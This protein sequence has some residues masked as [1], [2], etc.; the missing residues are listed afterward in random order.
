MC[1]FLTAAQIE[2]YGKFGDPPT[3]SELERFFF[4]DGG[5]RKLIAKRRDDATR[6]GF[7]LQLTTVRF[8][9]TLL[10]NPIDVPAT[11][12]AYV[13]AQLGRADASVARAY[14]KRDQTRLEHRWETRRVDG[15]RDFAESR[16]ALRMHV[17]RR[18]WT[19]G[20]GRN[21]IFDGAVAAPPRGAAAGGEHLDGGKCYRWFLQDH[22][23]L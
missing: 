19:T 3:D 1:A 16:E 6:L 2:L 14:L 21:A 11:I 18:A 7:A 4:L 8:L 9:G 22:T 15:W 10:A 17:D 13:A 23:S 20:D 12:M 5:D